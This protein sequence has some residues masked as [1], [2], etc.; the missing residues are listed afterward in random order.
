MEREIMFVRVPVYI[1]KNTNQKS[2]PFFV[3]AHTHTR[4]QSPVSPSHTPSILVLALETV[5][6]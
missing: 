5:A 2:A 1:E 4:T 6:P 3:L